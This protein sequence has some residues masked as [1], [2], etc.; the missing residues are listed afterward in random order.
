MI[1]QEVL[2]ALHNAPLD[3]EG[4]ILEA[5]NAT[6]RCETS[7][8]LRVVYKPLQGERPLWDF[9]S[10]TL[11]GREI[12]S[13][14]IDQSLDFSLIPPTVWRE[15][16]PAG[17][18]MC[19]LWV[20]E[21]PDS[22]LVDVVPPSEIEDGWIPIL[23][24]EDRMGR[25]VVLVHANDIRLQQ[26]A[27]LDSLINNGDRKGGHVLTDVDGCVWAVDHGVSLSVEPKLRTV[28]WGWADS[29][30]PDELLDRVEEFADGLRRGLP[31]L[32]RWLDDSEINA[33]KTRATDLINAG[34]FPVPSDD[35]PAIPWPVF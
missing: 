5:S 1:D 30:I 29:P 21:D 27:V 3:V 10:G 25:P 17:P 9:P 7:D 16:G 11:T 13:F 20:D 15:D 8:G 4:R 6:L 32:E 26:M 14:L 24:A 12:A 23:R 31:K 19:Q 2:A 34:V 33:L 28:L 22:R 18:G 35:W